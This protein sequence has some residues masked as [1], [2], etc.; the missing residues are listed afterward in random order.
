MFNV[1]VANF[2]IKQAVQEYGVKNIRIFGPGTAFS[3]VVPFM[4]IGLKDNS[5]EK[6]RTEFVIIEELYKIEDNYK[7]QLLAVDENTFG[8]ERF[9]QSDFNMLVNDGQFDVYVLTPDGYM[10]ICV[11][12]EN[13]FSKDE[14]KLINSFS[15][16][17]VFQQTSFN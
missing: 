12:I 10:P 8:K 13:I 5:S 17:G 4:G 6:T 7:V 15:N 9:Y 2:D 3:C 16:L 14:S 1:N 11:N